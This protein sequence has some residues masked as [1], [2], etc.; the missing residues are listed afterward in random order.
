MTYTAPRGTR[1]IL[2]KECRQ[3]QF[4]EHTARVL[5]EDCG[6]EE[7]KTPIFEH[8]DLFA[9]GI[10]SL[11]DIVEKEMYTFQD[12]KGRSLTLRPEGTAS[13]VRAYLENN[14]SRKGIQKLYYHGA[15]FRYERPQA[16]RYR[17]FEQIGVEVIGS[18]EPVVD[19]EVMAL[20]VKICEKLGIGGLKI[21]I[22]SVGCTVCRPVIREQLKSFIVSSLKFLCEDCQRR[23]E[24]NPLRILDCKN[25]QC[26]KY[27]SALPSTVS[28][29]CHECADHFSST[30]EYL[31]SAGISYH[32]D[33]FLV[34]GLDYYTKTVFEIRSDQLG[35][36]NSICGG[37]RYDE[38]IQELGG[39]KTP[40]FG[41]AFGVERVAMVMAQ[42]PSAVS[43]APPPMMVYLA[44]I[45][46]PAKRKAFSW[47]TQLCTAGIRVEMDLEGRSLK[48][49]LKYAS[50]HKIKYVCILGEDE[51][52]QGVCQLKNMEEGTQ[53]TIPLEGVLEEIKKRSRL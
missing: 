6:F 19:A 29:L 41:F 1:D 49:Q 45:G 21:A 37:G 51:L 14:L 8:T 31:D 33:A 4:I 43:F 15:M 47:L 12:K 50:E 17:Q 20:G 16:G 22:N 27:F 46:E 32:V 11:T 25:P 10:G 36:H 40:A 3:W 2:S 53:E 13:I 23:Y 39:R 34:R 7:I 44:V 18:K 42:Q 38:L 30:L 9:R 24:M 48:S 35:A 52:E 26:Q 28:V 5:L